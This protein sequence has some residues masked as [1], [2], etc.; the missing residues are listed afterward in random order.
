ML[1]RQWSA[2]SPIFQQ[3]IN[4]FLYASA[5][6]KRTKHYLR[7]CSPFYQR[8]DDFWLSSQV[9]IHWL[10]VQSI[11]QSAQSNSFYSLYKLSSLISIYQLHYFQHGILNWNYKFIQYFFCTCQCKYLSRCFIY[12]K[13]SPSYSTNEFIC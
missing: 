4:K 12:T 5:C 7:V 6:Q 10:R 11:E 13:H 8:N 1:F 3:Y 9:V 2:V